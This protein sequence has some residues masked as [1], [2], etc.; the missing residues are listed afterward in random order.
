RLHNNTVKSQVA[1][2]KAIY[3]DLKMKGDVKTNP[4]LNIQI[5]KKQATSLKYF[6][7]AQIGLIKEYCEQH[8]PQLW[9]ACEMQFYCFMRPKE[10]RFC[11]IY[12][13]DFE[14]NIIEVRG[15]I[16]KNGNTEKVVIPQHFS[17]R[18]QKYFGAYM[19]NKH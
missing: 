2:L 1:A 9:L 7:D 5:K 13:L 4:F 14:E 17:Q 6:N 8:D 19:P 18:M 3:A 12:D 10:M 11:K 15:E 16:S